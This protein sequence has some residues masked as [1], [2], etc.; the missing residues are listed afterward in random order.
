MSGWPYIIGTPGN[1][2]GVDGDL[3]VPAGAQSFT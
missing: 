1:L 2:A 3:V